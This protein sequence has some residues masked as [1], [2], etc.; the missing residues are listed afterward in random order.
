MWHAHSWQA[1]SVMLALVAV[2][3]S[4][5]DLT[6]ALDKAKDVVADSAAKGKQFVQ[7]K[8]DE[9]TEQVQEQLNLAGRFELTAGEPLMTDACYVRVIA[10]GTG[11]PTILQLQSYRDAERESFPSVFLQAQLQANSLAELVGEPLSARLFI[12][13]EP[14]GPILFSEISTPITL[15][16]TSLENQLVSAE[17]TGAALRDTSTGGDIPVTGNLTGVFD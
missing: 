3:C 14:E 15:T 2:G 1:A 9:T 13:R 17:L 6:G 5:E 8:M 7:E 11:R 12:Q 4:Q 16:I 10:P